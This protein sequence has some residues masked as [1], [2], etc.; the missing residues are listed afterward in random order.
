MEERIK[1]PFCGELIMPTAKKCRFCGE[2]LVQDA[3]PNVAPQT[4]TEYTPP[5]HAQTQPPMY[6][7]P[8]TSSME[9]TFYANTEYTPP[10]KQVNVAYCD[11]T[12]ISN[13]S[14][15][16]KVVKGFIPPVEK[17]YYDGIINK[18]QLDNLIV[19]LKNV[20][21]NGY[22]SEWDLDPEN[23]LDAMWRYVI[24]VIDLWCE[25]KGVNLGQWMQ[26]RI[27]DGGIHI[28]LGQEDS[29]FGY[30]FAYT[31]YYG[32]WQNSLENLRFRPIIRSYGFSNSVPNDSQGICFNHPLGEMYF[33]YCYPW[34]TRDYVVARL[35]IDKS[36]FEAGMPEYMVEKT[37]SGVYR[38]RCAAISDVKF[39]KLMYPNDSQI[40]NLALEIETIN[41]RIR[42]Q[43][44]NKILAWGTIAVVVA[45]IIKLM[46]I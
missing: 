39:A 12:T 7:P 41:E 36:F 43:K 14:T 23:S 9:D 28:D 19:N 46:L 32:D 15:F 2:W 34:V 42:N 29:F 25:K 13:H 37:H 5:E 30:L 40:L 24:N 16:N 11:E 18:P 26:N 10:V 4:P 17:L 21:D 27:D 44:N 3:Q 20:A 6:T 22:K 35:E 45:L 38:G 8:P 31:R 1:C 33:S